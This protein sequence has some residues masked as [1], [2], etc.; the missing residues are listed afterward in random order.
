MATRVTQGGDDGQEEYLAVDGDR[1]DAPRARARRGPPQFES[2]EEYLAV[3]SH[4]TQ[5]HGTDTAGQGGDGQEEYLAV[6]G[7]RAAV[8]MA[9]RVTQGGDDGQEEYLAVDGDRLDA[10]RAR[11]RRG[12][13]QFGSDEEYLA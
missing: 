13:P 2:D 3:N 6:D 1:L 8:A 7:D 11:A 10:P 12:P 5:P 9:T 4:G